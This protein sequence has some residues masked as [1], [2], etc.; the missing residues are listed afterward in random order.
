MLRLRRAIDLGVVGD[1]AAAAMS[2]SNSDPYR[3]D[4]V[5]RSR[6]RVPLAGR[7]VHPEFNADRVEPARRCRSGSMSCFRA[8]ALSASPCAAA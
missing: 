2:R 4:D 7:A 1:F 5:G 8:I 6:G 3:S